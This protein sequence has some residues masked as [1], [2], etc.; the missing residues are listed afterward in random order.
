MSRKPSCLISCS[1]RSPEGGL[2]AG[3]GRHGQTKPTA[4]VGR[5][6]GRNSI[7]GPSKARETA[8]RKDALD[9]RRSI[10][11]VEGLWKSVS[12]PPSKKGRSL[13]RPSSGRE[14]AQWG[15]AVALGALPHRKTLSQGV[16]NR[17]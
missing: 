9:C 2:A 8:K 10:A 13:E 12:W 4:R 14:R 16:A 11:L 6:G 5:T 15:A 1:H 7:R 17:V 3:V